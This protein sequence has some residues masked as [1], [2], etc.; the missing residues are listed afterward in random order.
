MI[1]VA[2]LRPTDL[3][4]H[5]TTEDGWSVSYLNQFTCH[6]NPAGE[7]EIVLAGPG[8]SR[9][10][11]WSFAPTTRCLVTDEEPTQEQLTE[12]YSA[13]DPK[14]YEIVSS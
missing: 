3:K 4:K 8:L 1:T 12:F 11:W 6:S 10:R 13:V 14:I 9:N 7:P 2:D 5:V